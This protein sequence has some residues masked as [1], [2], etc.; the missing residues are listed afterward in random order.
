MWA[1]LLLAVFWIAFGVLHSL[2][3]SLWLKEKVKK[4]FPRLYSYYR[5]GYSLFAF[6]SFG[7]VLYYQLSLTSWLLFKG[8]VAVLLAG[9]IITSAGL[10]IMIICIKKY[11]ISLSGIKSLI[12]NEEASPVLMIGGIHQYV[13]HPLYLGTFLFIWGLFLVLPYASLFIANCVITLYTLAGIK[14]EER[15]LVADFGESYRH[16]QQTVPPLLPRWKDI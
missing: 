9:I 15:K 11:F 8:L 4:N 14:L 2:L 7:G 5:L 16:Y 6:A 10:L 3:A 12:K 13:R 1:H